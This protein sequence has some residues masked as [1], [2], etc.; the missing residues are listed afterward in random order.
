LELKEHMGGLETATLFLINYFR[1]Q[2]INVYL[3]VWKKKYKDNI[4]WQLYLPNQKRCHAGDNILFFSEFV[5]SNHI[6]LIINVSGTSYRKSLLCLSVSLKTNVKLINVYHNNIFSIISSNKILGILYNSSG[7]LK[8]VVLICYRLIQLIPFY[9]GQ[10]YLYEHSNASI[11]LSKSYIDEFNYLHATKGNKSYVIENMF[12]LVDN[13]PAKILAEKEKIILFVGRLT[14]IK[15]VIELIKIFGLL[16]KRK[17]IKN[18]KL[19]IIG[20]GEEKQNLM[21]YTKEQS[22]IDDIIFLGNIDPSQYYQKAELL[23]LTSLFEGLPMVLLECQSWGV[24][25]IVY[26]SFAAARDIIEDGQN[27]CLVPNMKREIFVSRMSYILNN[28]KIKKSM[29]YNAMQFVRKYYS[30]KTLYDKWLFLF[31]RL[32]NSK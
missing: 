23:C 16:I 9:K 14:K 29:A 6:D 32:I 21:K 13:I 4:T 18:Y 19:I 22:L 31:D 27:G 15:N 3:I 20:D 10:R 11:F 8:K 12:F 7:I 5:N 1:K 28:D 30:H 25:P 26:N 17:I 2:K 24:I